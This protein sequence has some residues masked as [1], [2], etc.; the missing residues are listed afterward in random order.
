MGKTGPDNQNKLGHR[1]LLI[2]EEM[3]FTP[4]LVQKITI[5]LSFIKCKI[6]FHI[7]QVPP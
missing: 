3:F 5:T 1:D 4:I 6:V 7:S 2:N